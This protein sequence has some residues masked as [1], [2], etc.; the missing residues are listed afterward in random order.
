MHSLRR[1]VLLGA[2]LIWLALI[3]VTVG[4]GYSLGDGAEY[5]E[6]VYLKNLWF[7]WVAIGTPLCLIAGL[8]YTFRRSRWVWFG[9]YVIAGSPIFVYLLAIIS[10]IL[11]HKN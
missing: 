9:A 1:F 10:T 5:L 2:P 7:L 3:W 8:V 4:F 6:N 11:L